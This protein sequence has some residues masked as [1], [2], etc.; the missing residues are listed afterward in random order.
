MLSALE[1]ELIALNSSHKIVFISDG[2]IPIL[3]TLDTGVSEILTIPAT[4]AP[5]LL[6][7]C[8]KSD[9]H[10]FDY[11]SIHSDR[12]LQIFLPQ[13]LIVVNLIVAC[14]KNLLAALLQAANEDKIDHN[15]QKTTLTF[16]ARAYFRYGLSNISDSRLLGDSEA[17]F[18]RH[19]TKIIL[20]VIF[21]INMLT[22]GTTHEYVFI[23]W[24]I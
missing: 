10:S 13:R 22:H 2:P 24:N 11:L 3:D 12:K 18:C 4:R 6:S 23:Q 14:G 15:R 19:Q 17:C 5:V 8:N 7:Y 16:S 9:L 20:I 1:S 21:S